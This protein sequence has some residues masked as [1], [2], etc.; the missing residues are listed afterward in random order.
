MS[1]TSYLTAPPRVVNNELIYTLKNNCQG[2]EPGNFVG[3]ALSIFFAAK[4]LGKDGQ[5][6]GDLW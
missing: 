3:G 6:D 5:A 1:P 2:G 4:I